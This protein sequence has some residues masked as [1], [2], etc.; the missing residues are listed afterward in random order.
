[1]A[2]NTYGTIFRITTFGESHGKVNGV[3]MDGLPSGL[4]VNEREIEDDLVLRKPGKKYSTKRNEDDIPE[5]ISGIFNGKTTGAPLTIIIHNRDVESS[6]Y[7][8]NRFFPRPGHAD[9]PAMIKYGYDNWDFRGGGRLSA[10]ETVSRVVA[11]S[12]ARKLLLLKGIVVAGCVSNLGDMEFRNT[13]YEDCISSRRRELRTPSDSYEEIAEGLLEKIISENDSVGGSVQIIIRGVPAGLGE[14]VFD[15]LKANIAYAMLSIPG[16]TYF[17]MGDGLKQ[18]HSR[19]SEMMDK[20]VNK[21]GKYSWVKNHSGGISGGISTGDDIF[22]KIGFKPTSS[23]PRIHDTIDI[24]N[25]SGVQIKI[26]GR[27]DPSIVPRAVA[28]AE[29]MA[30]ILI[31][32]QLM[33]SVEFRK[34]ITDDEN[35]IMNELWKTYQRV[36]VR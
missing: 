21:K 10:R 26:V 25:G 32:D 24:R 1:M 13:G 36:E 17:E 27:H 22:F 4:M 14:P 6:Y 19:G 31:L 12:V 23:I 29:S 3:V 7:E 35:R 9:L 11:G 5:I 34:P 15:K 18:S 8:K 16:S 20:I 30:C 28:V 33:L 2:G